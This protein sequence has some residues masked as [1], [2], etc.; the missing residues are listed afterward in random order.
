VNGG[1]VKKLSLDAEGKEPVRL[2]ALT[3]GLFATVLTILVLDI[4]LPQPQSSGSVLD[5]LF[6]LWP[7]LFSYVLTFLIAGVFWLSHH[8][9]FHYIVR[10]NRRLLW[11]NLMF[12]L[13]V[14][15]FPFSTAEM[16]RRFPDPFAWD[17]YAGNMVMAGL[18]FFLMWSYAVAHNLVD[19]SLPRPQTRY[20]GL[21]H[22]VMPVIFIASALAQHLRPEGYWGPWLILAIPLVQALTDRVVLGRTPRKSRGREAVTE[23]LW[24]AAGLLPLILLVAFTVWLFGGLSIRR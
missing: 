5:T 21:R 13:F 16:S 19:P 14:G 3:D 4:R 1:S 2:I 9:D 23:A 12:L 15:L 8:R 11:F 24:W 7:H 18:M 20:N 22:L 17:L 10:Y 6:E